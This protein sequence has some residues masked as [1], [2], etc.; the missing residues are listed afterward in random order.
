VIFIPKNSSITFGTPGHA[1]FVYI[2][3]PADW[4]TS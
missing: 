1:R 4:N 2:A 3:F